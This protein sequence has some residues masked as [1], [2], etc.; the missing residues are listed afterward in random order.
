LAS[1]ASTYDSAPQK[2]TDSAKYQQNGIRLHKYQP[3]NY[4]EASTDH[5]KAAFGTKHGH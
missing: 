1:F 5:E 2:L 4:R 3:K